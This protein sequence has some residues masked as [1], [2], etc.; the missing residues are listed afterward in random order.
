MADAPILSSLAPPKPRRK[1]PVVLIALFAA[2]LLG[3]LGVNFYIARHRTLHLISGLSAPVTVTIDGG[4]PTTLSGPFPTTVPISE[5]A[6]HVAVSGGLTEEYDITVSTSFFG[7]YFN[8]PVFVLNP[9][10]TS[11][12]THETVV[13]TKTQIPGGGG[14][15]EYLYGQPYLQFQNLDYAFLPFPKSIEGSAD[16]S[17]SRSRIALVEE[18]VSKV[19]VRLLSEKKDVEAF[20]MAEWDLKLHPD[21]TPT[22]ELYAAITSGTP[23]A[24]QAQA[25]VKQRLK[26]RPLELDWHRVYLL[27]PLSEQE[28]EELA[29]DYDALLKS[30]PANSA[31][32]YLRGMLIKEGAKARPYF[33]QALQ[34]A[35]KSVWPHV[36]LAQY[37]IARGDWK[38]AKSHLETARTLAPDNEDI[39]DQY[40]DTRFALGEYQ[41]LESD[42]AKALQANPGDIKLNIHLCDVFIAQH[43][44]DEAK[45][46]AE[47]FETLLGSQNDGLNLGHSFYEYTLY[48]INSFPELE[49]SAPKGTKLYFQ[50]LFELGK[51]KELCELM[52]LASQAEPFWALAIC[53]AW[54]SKGDETRAKTWRAKAA[55]LFNAAPGGAPIADMLRGKEPPTV[56]AVADLGLSPKQE[57]TL[58]AALAQQFPTRA[59]EFRA[60]ARALNMDFAFPY[61]FLK[62]LLK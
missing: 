7:R 37:F 44:T 14:A 30:E 6:H 20:R 54:Q 56:E 45:A 19:M 59:D 31:A 53:A 27:M 13:Y 5:G 35:P 2:L 43:K 28:R 55:G 36:A 29:A 40:D 46:L 38:S 62:T 10:G 16:A 9:G 52:P 18:G 8:T 47:N 39:G 50:S 12:L 57:A 34:N 4:A 24:V 21:D 48:A 60:L 33:E 51:L 32:L 41:A 61:Y 22:L 26:R 58:L 42:L 49:K 17:I 3:A 25:F 1:P 23:S 15:F 11:L